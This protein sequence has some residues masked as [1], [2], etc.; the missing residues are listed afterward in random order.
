MILRAMLVFIP[1]SLVLHFVHASPALVFLSAAL[2]IVPLAGYM[3]EATEEL[4]KHLGPSVGGLLNATFGNA[5]EL[6]ITI[7]AVRAG[8]LDVVRAS[9]IGSIIGNI[10]LVLGLSIFAGGLK[11]KRQ[12]F[13]QDV[14]GSQSVMLILAVAAVMMPS[15]FVHALPD[16]EERVATARIENFSIW[17]AGLLIV[18]YLG[19]LLF[20]LVTHREMFAGESEA[21]ALAETPEEAAPKWSKTTAFFVLALATAGVAVMSEFLVSSIEPT[22]ESLGVSKL[23]VGVIVVPIIG[24]AAE[25]ATAVTMAIKNKMDVSLN[26]CMSSSVQIALFVAPLI[27][28]LSIPLGHAMPF[29]FNDFELIAVGF[30]ALI[31]ALIARDGDTNWFEGAQLLAVYAILALAFYF[32]PL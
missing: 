8:Q 22:V 4:A 23:F 31:A 16:L 10:L 14:A 12:K 19:S 25:H 6:I 28:F 1:I 13:N 27:V 20:S 26:I 18:L 7:F 2:A 3:G 11:H 15:L 9:I 24:N 5:T 29:V 21:Q 30:A 32:V 17:V